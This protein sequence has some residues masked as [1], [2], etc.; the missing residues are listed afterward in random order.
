M[1]TARLGATGER[2]MKSLLIAAS[3]ALATVVTDPHRFAPMLYQTT[4][5]LADGTP[6]THTWLQFRNRIKYV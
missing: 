5:Q 1:R 4:V 3:H 6:D 2:T